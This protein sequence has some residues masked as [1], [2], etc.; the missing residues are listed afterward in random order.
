MKALRRIKRDFETSTEELQVRFAS[1]FLPPSSFPPL[2]RK[3]DR[4]QTL[5]SYRRIVLELIRVVWAVQD[6]LT[7]H[8]RFLTDQIARDI[9]VLR[10]SPQNDAPWIQ[11]LRRPNRFVTRSAQ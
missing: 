10:I 8:K 1:S 4:N 5:S 6:N 3:L 7:Q 2:C 9:E 11:Q